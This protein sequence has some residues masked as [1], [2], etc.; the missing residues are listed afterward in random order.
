MP[1]DEQDSLN[2]IGRNLDRA[3][4]IVHR[5]VDT[6]GRI[7]AFGLTSAMLSRKSPVTADKMRLLQDVYDNFGHQATTN[8]LGAQAVSSV[9]R[10]LPGK[11]TRPL[12]SG[13]RALVRNK[14]LINKVIAFAGQVARAV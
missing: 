13:A 11:L 6:M 9:V 14:P 8:L 7:G 1:I 3:G 12:G 5:S 10:R 4:Q 2:D